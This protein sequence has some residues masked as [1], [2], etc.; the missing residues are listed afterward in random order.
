MTLL[1]RRLESIDFS[2]YWRPAVYAEAIV[3]ADGLLR[4]SQGPDL[5]KLYGL[6][7]RKLQI[8]IRAIYF[9]LSTFCIQ[10]D[11]TWVEK[12]FQQ[13]NFD[14]A[15]QLLELAVSRSPSLN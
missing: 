12:H 15:I 1:P 13:F 9:R 6:D 7:H 14:Q 3:I 8:L 5:L 4:F 11:K 2:L 10:A